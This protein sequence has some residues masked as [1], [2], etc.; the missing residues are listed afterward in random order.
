MSDPPGKAQRGAVTFPLL[1][2]G[3]PRTSR[4]AMDSITRL[5]L[6]GLCPGVGR[7]SFALAPS[8]LRQN[9]CL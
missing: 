5:C 1:E 6:D 4:A 9:G 7:F 2:V 3:I 8:E